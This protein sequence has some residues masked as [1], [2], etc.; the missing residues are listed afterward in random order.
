MVLVW[1][2]INEKKTV[3]EL[4]KKRLESHDL[5]PLPELGNDNKSHLNHIPPKLIHSFN[6][7]R[8]IFQT[9]DKVT[10]LLCWN[11][12]TR[13][14]GRE[15]KRPRA[16]RRFMSWRKMTKVAGCNAFKIIILCKCE[17]TWYM[18]KHPSMHNGLLLPNQAEHPIRRVNTPS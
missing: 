10:L 17:N 3:L 5:I 1:V 11:L 8:H 6:H 9:A 15:G 2:I 7:Y 12:A 16:V 4:R 18:L 13:S 14:H